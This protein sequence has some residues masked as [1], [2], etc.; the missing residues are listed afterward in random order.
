D[1]W[2]KGTSIAG[3]PV[4]RLGGA[5]QGCLDVYRQLWLTVRCSVLGTIIG[6]IPG[7]GSS[8]QW[9]AYAHTVHSSRDQSTFGKGDVRGVI[10]PGAAMNAREAGNLVTTLAFGVPGSVS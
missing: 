2:L 9:I 3:T 1:L 6:V 4:G 5:W 10:G 7:L 8:S